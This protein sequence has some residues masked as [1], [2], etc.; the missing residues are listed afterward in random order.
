M[1]VVLLF[2]V[3]AGVESWGSRRVAWEA[4]NQM[5]DLLLVTVFFFQAGFCLGGSVEYH[6]KKLIS[7]LQLASA[8]VTRVRRGLSDVHDE[9][10][11]LRRTA[12]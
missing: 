2:E 4:E 11:T 10:G 6:L 1:F 8:T 7:P 3:R 9:L 5:G 12:L